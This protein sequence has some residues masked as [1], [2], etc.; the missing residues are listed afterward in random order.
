VGQHEHEII[1]KCVTEVVGTAADTV[2][3]ISS[4]RAILK[5]PKINRNAGA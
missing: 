4:R 2:L 3:L 5:V 1:Q